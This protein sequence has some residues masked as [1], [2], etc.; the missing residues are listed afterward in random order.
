M[1]VNT[2]YDQA[3][4]ADGDDGDEMILQ[5]GEEYAEYEGEEVDDAEYEDEE[6]GEG[7]CV[8]DRLKL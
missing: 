5:E 1:S 8:R 2:E 6:D 3:V 7:K 4:Y